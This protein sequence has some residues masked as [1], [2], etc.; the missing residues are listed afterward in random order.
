MN[1][2]DNPLN[3]TIKYTA[4]TILLVL[5]GFFLPVVGLFTSV[6]WFIPLI[7]LSVRNGFKFAVAGIIVLIAVLTVTASPLEALLFS[8]QHVLIALVYCNLF[9]RKAEFKE[10]LLGGL[11]AAVLSALTR[12]AVTVWALGLS[13]K[14]WLQYMRNIAD[15]VIKLYKETGVWEQLT[16]GPLT[17]QDLKELLYGFSQT[18]VNLTPAALT[19][20]GMLIAFIGLLIAIRVLKRNGFW[21][22]DV[23]EFS[24]WKLP[25]QMA[26]P[27][28]IALA[29][30]LLGDYLANRFFLVIGQ[31]LVYVLIPVYVVTGFAAMVFFYNKL[32]TSVFMKMVFLAI[33]VFNFPLFLMLLL[34]LGVFDPLINF[35]KLKQT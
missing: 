7:M 6:V 20:Y 33:I 11:L 4:L 13:Y 3:N 35:R 15:Q 27:A 10:L 31:N 32:K 18:M 19:T 5:A 34:L 22:P 29:A 21:A 14:K 16:A 24:R 17:G 28:I 2:L 30:L 25:W 12:I 1:G 26:W 8:S 9:A 23:P